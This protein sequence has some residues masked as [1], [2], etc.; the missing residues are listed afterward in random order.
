MAAVPVVFV[1]NKAVISVLIVAVN[2]KVALVSDG[3]TC[4]SCEASAAIIQNPV[5]SIVS[6]Q[7]PVKGL[8]HQP[9]R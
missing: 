6:F 7:Q 8:A 3:L 2:A 5:N 9:I 1:I 4:A